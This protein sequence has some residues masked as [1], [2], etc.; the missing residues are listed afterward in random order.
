MLAEDLFVM[1]KKVNPGP[2][3]L[4]R[5]ALDGTGQYVINV[6]ALTGQGA[7][8]PSLVHIFLETRLLSQ[9]DGAPLSFF[10]F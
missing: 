1:P 10:A 2:G 9:L 7:R 4:P 5:D 3:L 8:A 6:N